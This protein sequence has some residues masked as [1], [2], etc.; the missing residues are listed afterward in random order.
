MN[1]SD[2]VDGYLARLAND[3]IA[4]F[5]APKDS[6]DDD[7][8][9]PSPFGI[10]NE[11]VQHSPLYAWDFINYVLAEDREEV[12]LDLLAAGPLENF[13]S[14][15]GQEWIETIEL[16]ARDNPR[17]QTLLAGVWQSDTPDEVWA[18]IVLAQGTAKSFPSKSD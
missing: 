16:H 6:R 14:F 9:L 17:F 11:L 18:P 7:P 8:N 10:V 12:T 13:V 5:S 4:Y 3:W 15:H 2:L 1:K